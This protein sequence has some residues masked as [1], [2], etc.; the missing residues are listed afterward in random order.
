M[1]DLDLGSNSKTQQDELTER[2]MKT[3]EIKSTNRDNLYTLAFRDTEP[4]K[5]KRVVQSLVSIFVE[6]GLGENAR[7]RIRQKKFIDDQI[8]AYEKKEA[9]GR[10]G[11]QAPQ[12]RQSDCGRKGWG[13]A[14]GRREYP[15][16]NPGGASRSGEFSGCDQAANRWRRILP[17]V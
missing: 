2:L 1:A 4:E 8:R 10:E 13:R 11:F 14:S 6:S 3:L 7:I 16:R 9:E 17:A 12:Y 15:A 5:A